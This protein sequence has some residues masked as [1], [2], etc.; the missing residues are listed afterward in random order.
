MTNR[1]L[2]EECPWDRE[3]THHTL[4]S[5]LVEEAYE[6]VEALSRLPAAAPG[7]DIDHAGYALVEEELGDLL[8]QVVFHATLAREAG[9]FDVEEIAE[10]IRRKLV[11]R[12]PHVFGEVEAEDAATVRAN[13]EELKR[14]EK[15]RDSLMD[16]IPAALPATSKA[17]KLQRRAAS[18]GFDWPGLEP[19]L[20]KLDEE[21]AELRAV[22]GDEE[23]ALDELGDVLFAVVNVARHLG[24]DS[25]LALRRANDRFEER[26]RHLEAGATTAGHR[27]DDLSLEEMD[28]LWEA[29]KTQLAAGGD[30]LGADTSRPAE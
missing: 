20:A 5:H 17:D 15:E 13:W 2:R 19:V 11:R 9:V 23:A 22:T 30:P 16:D 29:A 3:Q 24:L 28:A 4:V 10:Q 7:G 6:T 8:L 18:A 14:H 21:L 1:R 26:F 25:E 27:L 12:H